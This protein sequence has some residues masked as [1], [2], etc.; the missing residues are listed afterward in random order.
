LDI[1]L[2]QL[3]SGKKDAFS[4]IPKDRI[5]YLTGQ[6]SS[7]TPQMDFLRGNN[8]IMENYWK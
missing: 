4:M 6:G 2:D 1:D 3:L 8:I 7:A 5:L